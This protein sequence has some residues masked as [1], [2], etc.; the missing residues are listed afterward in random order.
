MTVKATHSSDRMKHGFRIHL[1][2]AA[3][4]AKK[5]HYQLDLHRLVRSKADLICYCRWFDSRPGWIAFIVHKSLLEFMWFWI[6]MCGQQMHVV[7]QV[8]SGIKASRLF[9]TYRPFE[10]TISS[11]TSVTDEQNVIFLDPWLFLNVIVW[12]PNLPLTVYNVGHTYDE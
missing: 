7:L 4:Q 9:N 3:G 2:F 11:E 5:L 10:G 12:T 1:I 8:F 6:E